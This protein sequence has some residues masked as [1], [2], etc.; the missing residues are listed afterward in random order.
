MRMSS[1]KG[2]AYKTITKFL[3]QREEKKNKNNSHFVSLKQIKQSNNI[4]NTKGQ[5]NHK[6]TRKKKLKPKKRPKVAKQ[7]Q[8]Q[9]EKLHTIDM[10]HRTK[11]VNLLIS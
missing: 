5:S 6:T 11:T 8:K 10:L 9:K 4:K 7:L 1:N 2:R 3:I